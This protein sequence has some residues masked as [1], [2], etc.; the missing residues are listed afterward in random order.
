MGDLKHEADV[1]WVSH[2]VVPAD[3]GTKPHA[4]ESFFHLAYLAAGSAAW[5]VDGTEY[6]AETGMCINISPGIQHCM[7]TSDDTCEIYEIKYAVS[8]RSLERT[9]RAGHCV[10]TGD[11]LLS[12]LVKSVYSISRKRTVQAR[13][14]GDSYLCALLYHMLRLSAGDEPDLE[15]GEFL[16]TRTFSHPTRLT[17]KYIDEHYSQQIS[18]D[19]L[20]RDS[21][22]NRNYLCMAFKRDCGFT[23]NEYLNYVRIFHAAEMIVYGDYSLQQI[24]TAVGFKDLSYFTKTF[25]KIVGIPPGQ[26]R[27]A[28]PDGIFITSD[29]DSDQEGYTL[30]V[31]AGRVLGNR[32]GL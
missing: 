26:Y 9:L 14:E 32:E 18:L 3:W 8:N 17:V 15:A 24:C 22:Y 1:L 25:R 19:M 21:G 29:V 2:A 4:H 6:Y 28:F 30:P 10:L 7:H 27:Q 12:E 13:H 11:V 5:F 20:A 16:T 23:I 31:W